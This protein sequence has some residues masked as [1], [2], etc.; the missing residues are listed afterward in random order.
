MRAARGNLIDLANKRRRDNV[1]VITTN[2]TIKRNGTLVMG[3]GVARDFRDNFPGL[4]KICAEAVAL[5][6]ISGTW[7]YGYLPIRSRFGLFQVKIHYKSKASFYLIDLSARMLASF[8][9]ESEKTY[10]IN[11]PGIGNGGLQ[12]SAVRKVL[13]EAG[14]G[15]L[16]NIV[17]WTKE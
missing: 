5:V 7:E 14:W 16:D 3:R 17:V 12:K 2:A 11:Y 1:I 6:A 4:D 9:R 13:L 10:H 15:K 8:A